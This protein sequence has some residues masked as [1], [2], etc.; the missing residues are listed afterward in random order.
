MKKKKLL[1]ALLASACIAAGASAFAACDKDSGDTHDS[2]LYAAYQTYKES[3]DNPMEYDKWLADILDKLANGGIEGPKGDKG[4]TGAAGKGIKNI[5]LLEDSEGKYFRFTY[6][7]DT[8]K[9]V[10]IENKEG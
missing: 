7:D 5:E 10:R 3:V 6:T 2:A 1:L 8:T 9:D 4:D